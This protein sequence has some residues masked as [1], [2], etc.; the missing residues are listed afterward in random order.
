LI[1]ELAL[2]GAFHEIPEPLFVR[3]LHPQI[4]TRANPT[5]R[6][7]RTVLDPRWEGAALHPELRLIIEHLKI[8]SRAPIGQADRLK[9]YALLAGYTGWKAQRA[10][11]LPF[12]ALNR[13]L[14]HREAGLTPRAGA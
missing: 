11:G 13:K 10:A 2:R 3:R 12:R 14:T 9:C 7:R 4:T 5:H 8:V 1:G 6:S